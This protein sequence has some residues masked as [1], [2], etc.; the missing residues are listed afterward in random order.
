MNVPEHEAKLKQI[1]V[2]YMSGN[3]SRSDVKLEIEKLLS[4]TNLA[5]KLRD[6]LLQQVNERISLKMKEKLSQNQYLMKIDELENQIIE[7]GF[8][9]GFFN[10]ATLEEIEALDP[11][12]FASK[13]LMLIVIE[14]LKGYIDNEQET[15]PKLKLCIVFICG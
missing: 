14:A 2:Q 10:E 7:S 6:R 15:E 4:E 5:Y 12:V 3:L 1:N 8:P 9:Y 13:I 11:T